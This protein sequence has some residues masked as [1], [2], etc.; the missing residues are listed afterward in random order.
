MAHRTDIEKTDLITDLLMTMDDHI[1]RIVD[2]RT[3]GIDHNSDKTRG[4]LQ[5]LLEKILDLG[6]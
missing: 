5:E 3:A 2:E 6:S 1:S 4:E